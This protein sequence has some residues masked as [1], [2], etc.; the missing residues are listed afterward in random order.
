MFLDGNDR[1]GAVVQR[2][3]SDRGRQQRSA[4]ESD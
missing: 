2:V 3:L 1:I 4:E